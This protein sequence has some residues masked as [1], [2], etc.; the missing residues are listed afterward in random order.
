MNNG[1]YTE[2]VVESFRQTENDIIRNLM[3]ATIIE[4]GHAKT[5]ELQCAE[6]VILPTLTTYI[7][8]PCG[9]DA[10]G[11]TYT[12]RMKVDQLTVRQRLGLWLLGWK[13]V[14]V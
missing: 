12:R 8:V 14:K 10:A 3:K 11:N 6:P 2:A 7:E 9:L 13:T 1:S 5:V 4:N